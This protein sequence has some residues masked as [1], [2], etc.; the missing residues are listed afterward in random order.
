M[1]ERQLQL[2]FSA[3][4][5]KQQPAGLSAHKVIEL[6]ICL[7]RGHEC[8]KYWEKEWARLCKAQTCRN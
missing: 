8:W 1:R 2:T 6:V 4:A 3:H 5:K 7:H